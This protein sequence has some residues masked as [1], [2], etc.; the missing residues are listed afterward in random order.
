MNTLQK[1]AGISAISEAIIYIVAFIYFGA[2]WSY[3][4]AEGPIE[5]MA[6][7][8]ENQLIFSSIYF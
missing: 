5:K 6:Y 8:A 1:L 4:S 7:L 3:P 2:F